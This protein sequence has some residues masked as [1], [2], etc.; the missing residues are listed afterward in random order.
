MI[1]NKG[2][3]KKILNEVAKRLDLGIVR[4]K[5]EMPIKGD[6]GQYSLKDIKEEVIDAMIYAASL[7]VEAEKIKEK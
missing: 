2:N 7:L 3:N 6:I 4:F 1:V 5:Q